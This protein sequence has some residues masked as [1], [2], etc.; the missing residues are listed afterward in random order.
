MGLGQTAY[1][2][3]H[4]NEYVRTIAR[5]MFESPINLVEGMKA[6]ERKD[7]LEHHVYELMMM[8]EELYEYNRNVIR[9]MKKECEYRD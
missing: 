7:I 8:N 3:H 2:R 5:Q 1:N 4:K 6:A 9:L